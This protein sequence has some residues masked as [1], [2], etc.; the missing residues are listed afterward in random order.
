MKLPRDSS[1]AKADAPTGADEPAAQGH[2]AH[3]LRDGLAGLRD[4]MDR[5]LADPGGCPWDRAQTLDTLRPYLIEE[6]YE[7]LDALDDPE[8]H[9]RELG[10]L[11]FQ[12]VFQSALRE[13]EGAFDLEGVIAAIRDKMIRRHPHVFAPA[14]GSA[15]DAPL[16]ADD[17]ARQW[18]Q[19]KRAENMSE[20]TERGPAR[21]LAGVP[22]S[23]PALQRAWRLQDKAAAVG[24]DWPTIQGPVD[25]IREEWEELERA[26]AEGEPKAIEE[27]FGDL[28]FVLVRYGQKLGIAAED[29]LRATCAKFES[30]F[31]FV[32]ERCHAAGIE[33]EAAGLERL[34]GWWDEAKARA[35]AGRA[36]EPDVPKDS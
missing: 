25:K 24:F 35:R 15:D 10:D 30:R 11:L 21:P 26:R 16:D 27:E 31:A 23:L 8:A 17:V 3:G 7:V 4:L 29:A 22:R 32:M 34:D 5:L 19:L 28:L 12:I 36:S 2:R 6:A 14:A 13:R 20:G 18:A 33:P 9:R 1:E